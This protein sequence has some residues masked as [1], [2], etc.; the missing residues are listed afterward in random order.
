MDGL[1]DV[2]RLVLRLTVHKDPY[3]IV[4]K[5]GGAVETCFNFELSF[6]AEPEESEEVDDDLDALD[7]W[8]R[9]EKDAER[10]ERRRRNPVVRVDWTG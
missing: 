3:Y 1:E 7:F 4:E 6:F 9:M 10:D 5:I 2:T 8:E